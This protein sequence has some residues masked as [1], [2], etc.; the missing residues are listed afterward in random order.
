MGIKEIVSVAGVVPL[1]KTKRE[2]EREI[3]RAH[4]FA[5]VAAARAAIAQVR[6]IGAKLDDR[7]KDAINKAWEGILDLGKSLA[8]GTAFEADANGETIEDAWSC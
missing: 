4:A 7:E 2:I 8:A 5:L 1:Q 6:P 3:Y